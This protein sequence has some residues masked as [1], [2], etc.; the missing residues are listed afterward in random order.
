MQDT[1]VPR[2]TTERFQYEV[3]ATEDHG[4]LQTTSQFEFARC[5][6]SIVGFWGSAKPQNTNLF[7]EEDGG[8]W[9]TAPD[10]AKPWRITKDRRRPHTATDE[11]G[12]L[13]NR[14]REVFELIWG[15][16]ALESFRAQRI[17]QGVTEDQGGPTAGNHSDTSNSSRH[18]GT[19]NHGGPHW[20]TED[21]APQ[22]E[23]A[24]CLTSFQSV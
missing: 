23:F 6:N 8:P 13:S 10:H 21:H 1:T 2:R 19:E 17:R 4:G 15:C 24:K 16:L 20:A 9:R 7:R 18:D 22:L 3:A 5:L 14:I 11:H 12:D